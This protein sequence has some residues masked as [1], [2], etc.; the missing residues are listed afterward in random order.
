VRY[1]IFGCVF[2]ERID[3]GIAGSK[4]T[5]LFH[6][7]EAPRYFDATMGRSLE[8]L[9]IFSCYPEA[10]RTHN[11]SNRSKKRTILEIIRFVY[12]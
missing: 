9:P 4:L 2:V 1:S 11:N 12:R 10:W 3:V 6:H 5:C 7:G 8:L